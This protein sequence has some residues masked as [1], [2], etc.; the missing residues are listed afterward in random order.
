MSFLALNWDISTTIGLHLGQSFFFF[1]FSW[2]NHLRTRSHAPS[3]ADERSQFS[4]HVLMRR[5]YLLSPKCELSSSKS[6][7]QHNDWP[8]HWP[9]RLLPVESSPSVAPRAFTLQHFSPCMSTWL[10]VPNISPNWPISI[11]R[12]TST[13]TS[14]MWHQHDD[15]SPSVANTWQ[16]L[17]NCELNRNWT[18]TERLCK[19]KKKKKKREKNWKKFGETEWALLR[20]KFILKAFMASPQN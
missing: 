6:G 19:K 18:Q 8:F 11:C 4:V 5:H 9:I 10:L 3:L 13:V 12:H 16:K 17:L 14:A 7:N 1:F 20:S 15:V 2:W